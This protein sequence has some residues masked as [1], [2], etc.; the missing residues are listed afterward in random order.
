M[1]KICQD[2]ESGHHQDNQ[3]HSRRRPSIKGQWQFRK[4]R[5]LKG[6]VQL[7]GSLG[8]PPLRDQTLLNRRYLAFR[9]VKGP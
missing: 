7:G 1:E 8:K 2:R 9:H 6:L 3:T 4:I 5:K